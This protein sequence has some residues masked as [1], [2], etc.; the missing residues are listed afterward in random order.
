MLSTCCQLLHICFPFATLA[1]CLAKSHAHAAC[2]APCLCVCVCVCS[3]QFN[4]FWVTQQG[5]KFQ[6]LQDPTGQQH[7]HTHTHT[8]SSLKRCELEIHNSQ[9]K[10]YARIAQIQFCICICSWACFG[11]KFACFFHLHYRLMAAEF[12]IL[13]TQTQ[14]GNLHK[15]HP[16][17]PFTTV[18]GP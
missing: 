11:L 17:H 7:R 16:T 8:Q 6:L 18:P 10:F 3:L 15:I 5:T 4:Y 13:V 2:H 14:Q 1:F 9:I 12:L